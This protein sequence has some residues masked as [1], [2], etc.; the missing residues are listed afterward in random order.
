MD[1]TVKLVGGESGIAGIYSPESMVNVETFHGLCGILGSGVFTGERITARELRE[2]N[3]QLESFCGP[4][5]K[6]PTLYMVDGV[7][8][9]ESVEET[10]GW[11]KEK[12]SGIAESVKSSIEA[13]KK[14]WEE[15]RNKWVGLKRRVNALSGDHEITPGDV[16]LGLLKNPSLLFED[17]QRIQDLSKTLIALDKTTHLMLD[18]FA[19]PYFTSV[20]KLYKE[21]QDIPIFLT[22]DQTKFNEVIALYKATCDESRSIEKFIGN[23]PGGAQIRHAERKESWLS[24]NFK[25]LFT[26][27]EFR[28][29]NPVRV[30][31]VGMS[32]KERELLNSRHLEDT[33]EKLTV[34][35]IADLCAHYE[36]IIDKTINDTAHFESMWSGMTTAFYKALASIRLSDGSLIHPWAPFFS[37]GPRAIG[38]ISV[39]HNDNKGF[40]SVVV[41]MCNLNYNFAENYV[42]LAEKSV[43]G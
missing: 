5:E 26:S 25:K 10:L 14:W 37:N 23:Y 13:C 29:L 4:G 17:G 3:A 16:K 24:N 32:S 34:K 41:G 27:Y 19:I 36:N 9:T 7:V 8:S 18:T 2:F 12:V 31:F 21:V 38:L 39:I 6:V 1:V 22:K 35:E 43:R 42:R 40:Y 15:Y 33:V 28:D 11:I 20:S 30:E